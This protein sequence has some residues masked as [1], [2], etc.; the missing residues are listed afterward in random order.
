MLSFLKSLFG[1]KPRR[2][3]R[4]KKLFCVVRGKRKVSCHR[5]KSTARQRARA[6]R[7]RGAKR[8]RVARKG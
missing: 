6:L 5:K 4:A 8:V 1:S 3:R 2:R 7:A